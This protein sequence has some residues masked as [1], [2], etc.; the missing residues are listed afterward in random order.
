MYFNLKQKTETEI[1]LV[2]ELVLG[3]NF[4]IP[5]KRVMADLT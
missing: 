3:F 2:T 1:T 4:I 5:T